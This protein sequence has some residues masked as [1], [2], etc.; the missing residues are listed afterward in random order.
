MPG[1]SHWDVSAIRANCVTVFRGWN[2]G[3]THA[4]F[5]NTHS[6]E[7]GLFHLAL[8]AVKE[9]MG[10]SRALPPK[11]TLVHLSSEDLDNRSTDETMSLTRLNF[12]VRAGLH[13]SYRCSLNIYGAPN[14]TIPGSCG[15]SRTM[16]VRRPS[17]THCTSSHLNPLSS[18]FSSLCQNLEHCS[19]WDKGIRVMKILLIFLY[20]SLGPFDRPAISDGHLPF[21]ELCYPYVW[22]PFS[23]ARAKM[24]N[25]SVTQTRRLRVIFK[26]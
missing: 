19:G 20:K 5:Q 17:S 24:C 4:A 11:G 25:Y 21:K 18:V 23:G 14:D 1:Y 26:N 16:E 22:N 8:G 9:A 7:T 13:T 12:K 15:K 2:C 6:R 10:C 3:A